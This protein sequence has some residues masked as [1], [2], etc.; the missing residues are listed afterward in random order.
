[1][2]EIGIA[3]P[4]SYNALLILLQLRGGYHAFHVLRRSACPPSVL[5]WSR[6]SWPKR[7][8]NL[9]RHPHSLGHGR[10]RIHLPHQ[11]HDRSRADSAIA[12]DQ[13]GFSQRVTLTDRSAIA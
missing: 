12:R 4:S 13:S 9:L 2:E 1:M 8:S 7:R 6:T 5:S 3:V 11:E 10:G